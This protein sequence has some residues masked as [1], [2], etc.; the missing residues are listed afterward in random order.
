MTL[1]EPKIEI[2]YDKKGFSKTTD[3]FQIDRA[4]TQD[5][6]ANTKKSSMAKV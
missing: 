5:Q 3:G 1:F 2:A 4:L 6:K